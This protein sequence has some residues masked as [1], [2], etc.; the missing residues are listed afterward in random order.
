MLPLILSTASLILCAVCAHLFK[1]GSLKWLAFVWLTF[2]ACLPLITTS[3]PLLSVFVFVG[4][5]CSVS[6]VLWRE[7][8]RHVLRVGI[9]GSLITLSVMNP[10]LS[11]VL[12][13]VSVVLLALFFLPGFGPSDVRSLIFLAP[14]VIAFKPSPLALTL[15]MIASVGGTIA[16]FVFSPRDKRNSIPFIPILF[17]GVIVGAVGQYILL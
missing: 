12:W 2:A 16:F 15:F 8:S 4:L 11:P 7:A 10:K 5:T 9:L 6:D 14:Y 3:F 1:R 13:I 17:F